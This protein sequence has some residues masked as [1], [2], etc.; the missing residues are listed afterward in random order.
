MVVKDIIIQTTYINIYFIILIVLKTKIMNT[1]NF[2][3]LDYV[4]IFSIIYFLEVVNFYCICVVEMLYN[5]GYHVSLPNSAFSHMLVAWNQPSI[6]QKL[7]NATNHR[8][9]CLFVYFREP[10]AKYLSAHHLSYN[11]LRWNS[12]SEEDLRNRYKISH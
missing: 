12:R 5:G 6:P 8:V 7:A 3:L 4:T 1:Q 11:I 2:M 10:V 9:F